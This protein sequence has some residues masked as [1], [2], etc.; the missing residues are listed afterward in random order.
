ML[1]IK[2]FQKLESS[3]KHIKNSKKPVYIYG[4]GDGCEKILSVM[5]QKGIKPDGIFASDDF[6]RGKLFHGYEVKSLSYV[7]QN[8]S[9]FMAVL[10]FGTNLPEIM[11]RIDGIAK[12]HEVIAP[13]VSVIGEGHFEKAC[14]LDNF[15]RAEKAYSLLCDEQ[16]RKVFENL[17]AFKITENTE[18]LRKIFTETKEA[19]ELLN[20][21]ENEIYC[22]LG[23]YN[24]DTVKDFCSYTNGIYRKIYALE[25]ERNNFQ[26]CV[27]NTFDL[28]NIEYHNAAAAEKDSCI[29]FSSKAGRQAQADKNG[30]LISARSLDSVL[31]GRECTYI[32]YDVEGADF[33]ALQGSIQTIRRYSP[34][35]CTALYHRPYDYIDMPLYINDINS[36]YSFF[37]RQFTYYPAWETNLI[38]KIL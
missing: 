24:G 31:A 34:K 23:A 17:S 13:D 35:I 30:K 9:D 32:K 21:S 5:E 33:R 36:D 18:F 8:E 27:R 2:Y 25:P 3:W 19:Y 37:M 16:S 26:K 22:D 20:L 6:A 29:G 38:C 12:R 4:M 11:E 1:D 28:D 10:A 15:Y 7:E 14:F